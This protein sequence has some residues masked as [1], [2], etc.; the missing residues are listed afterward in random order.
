MFDIHPSARSNFDS[1]VR[2]LID[3]VEED[4]SDRSPKKQFQSDVFIASTISEA[5]VIGDIEESV[6]DYK[7]NTVGRFF[8]FDGKK[9]GLQGEKYE[10]LVAIAEKIQR[11][12][13]FSERLSRRFVED[14]IYRWVKNKFTGAGPDNDFI[15]VL[16]NE[17]EKSV[18]EFTMLVPISNLIVEVPF[19]FCGAVIKNL[20]ETYV[21]R[22]A[23]GLGQESKELVDRKNDFLDRFRRKYQGYAVVEVVLLCE[24]DYASEYC[25]DL[26]NKICDLLGIYSGAALMPDLKCAS[27]PKGSESIP[28]YATINSSEG[29]I[30][31]KEGILDVAS[32]RTWFIRERDLDAFA[33]AGLGILSELSLKEKL[34]SYEETVLNLAFLYSKSAFTSDPL[35]KLV[36]I[37]SAL[38]STLLKNQSEPI[39]QNI[40]E[41]MAFFICEDGGSRKEVIRNLKVVYGFRSQYLHHGHSIAELKELSLFF[42]NFWAFFVCAINNYRYFRDK[43]HLIEF[44]DNKKFGG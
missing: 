30:T 18:S 9:Y 35:E 37:L 41:R 14:C 33:Q 11:L 23:E 19:D 1:K 28:F 24:P 38:E 40:A 27:R 34:S 17:G 16:I 26:A 6:S 7:G 32:S 39:Q 36:Y 10:K 44:I 13:A 25:L 2:D 42:K 22:M 20:S 12:P 31:I 21:D 8:V 4:K 29:N 5:D 3:L 43:N 15:T